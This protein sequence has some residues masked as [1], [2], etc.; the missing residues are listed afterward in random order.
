MKRRVKLVVV[1]LVAVIAVVGAIGGVKAAQ[2]G[3]MIEEGE[4][5][6]P[7]PIGVTTAEVDTAEW[8]T[9]VSA[10]GTAVA[11]QEVMLTPEVPGRITALRFESGET[12]ER[13]QVLVTLDTATERAQL[14]SARAEVELANITL[15]RMQAL[16]GRGAVS[17]AEFDTARARKAQADASVQGL[18]AVI[19][20]KTLRAP[21]SGRLGIREADL[22]QVLQPGTPIVSLQS[23]DPIYVDFQVPENMLASLEAGYAVV[24]TSD[25]FP[26]ESFRGTIQTIN[27]R[28]ETSTRNVRI[29]AEIPNPDE[30]LRPG[31]FLDVEVVRPQQRRIVAVPNT[32]VLYA[33]YGDSVYI[34]D[35][36][37]NGGLVARQMFVRLG[38]RRGDLVEVVSGLEADQTVVSTGAFKLQ[39]APR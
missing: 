29:R 9:T 6:V 7:P 30:R 4:S 18:R 38:E 33:P 10:I 27:N 16:A 31:M 37:E 32:A 25:A 24:A 14:A 34:V 19:A 2:I 1:A 36:G 3:A 20:Q 8:E 15:E 5:F 11:T 12:V 22:G 23:L 35:E 39:N 28:V 17:Q 26:E 21:F 13:G